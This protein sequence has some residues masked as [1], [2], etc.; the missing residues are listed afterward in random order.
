[1]R[2]AGLWMLLTLALA[3]PAP[4]VEFECSRDISREWAAFGEGELVVRCATALGPSEQFEP[5]RTS[6]PGSLEAGSAVELRLTVSQGRYGGESGRAVLVHEAR[7]QAGPGGR[8]EIRLAIRMP[9]GWS[10]ASELELRLPDGRRAKLDTSRLTSQASAG[11]RMLEVV[12]TD[13]SVEALPAAGVAH[14]MRARELARTT[15]ARLSSYPGIRLRGVNLGELSPAAFAS[16]RDWVWRG[17]ELEFDA[18]AVS[19]NRGSSRMAELWPGE[20]SFVDRADADSRAPAG[21][22]LRRRTGLGTVSLELEPGA[23][24]PASDDSSDTGRQGSSMA[25]GWQRWLPEEA[26]AASREAGFLGWVLAYGLGLVAVLARARRRGVDRMLAA[27]LVA[28]V[29]FAGVV[30]VAYLVRPADV[31][32]HTVRLL[33]G[34]SGSRTQLSRL[35]VTGYSRSAATIAFEE[36]AA[37]ALLPAEVDR[38]P[39]RYDFGCSSTPAGPLT[40]RQQEAGWSASAPLLPAQVRTY[41]W[42]GPAVEAG[43]LEGE[44]ELD[45]AGSRWT[46]RVA[47]HLTFPLDEVHLVHGWHHQA[48]GPL[49]Q[50]R[51]LAVSLPLVELSTEVECRAC[52]YGHGQML[53]RCPSCGRIHSAA[54]AI[55]NLFELRSEEDRLVLARLLAESA[56]AREFYARPLLIGLGPVERGGAPGVTTWRR[57]VLV[58]AL[59]QRLEASPR[60]VPAAAATRLWSVS[61]NRERTWRAPPAGCTYPDPMRLRSWLEGSNPTSYLFPYRGPVRSIRIELGGAGGNGPGG[62]LLVSLLNARSNTYQEFICRKGESL[63]VEEGAENFFD[64]RDGRVTLQASMMSQGLSRLDVSLEGG[65]R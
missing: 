40:V 29:V 27:L 47:S 62:G 25:E 28:P 57:T 49:A 2:A 23:R 5:V 7:M 59:A 42:E 20:D 17:G 58:A 33:Y 43:S 16:L 1:M 60:A 52:G 37:G 13:R 21:R 45:A 10:S 3:W 63:V 15:G 14:R 51:T 11:S 65:E 4:A 61:C 30:V 12:G 44:L 36:P 46:G 8:G 64:R 6:L 50:G 19:S 55:Y 18:A 26:Q 32:L 54:G 41:G 34:Q 31:R 9:S 38:E 56:G 53:A 39:G 22:V 48:L 35:F 24:R